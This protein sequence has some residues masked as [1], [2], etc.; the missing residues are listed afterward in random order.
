MPFSMVNQLVQVFAAIFV[1]T[2]GLVL[3]DRLPSL[4]ERRSFRV[5]LAFGALGAVLLTAYLVLQ[6]QWLLFG[7]V[8]GYLAQA[9]LIQSFRTPPGK[10]YRDFFGPEGLVELRTSL[11]PRDDMTRM[12]LR[13][14]RTAKRQGTECASRITTALHVSRNGDGL[15]LLSVTDTYQ[16]QM[17]QELRQVLVL[18]FPV[19]SSSPKNGGPVT[20]LAQH[21]AKDFGDKW[22]IYYAPNVS[23]KTWSGMA[24]GVKATVFVSRSDSPASKREAMV[25]RYAADGLLRFEAPLELDAQW[26]TLTVSVS[27]FP[28]I[29][30]TFHFYSWMAATDYWEFAATAPPEDTDGLRWQLSAVTA[31]VMPV[32]V[33]SVGAAGLI[34]L[35]ARDM[36]VLPD[37]AV[38]A[39]LLPD[40]E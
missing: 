25:T 31:G 3:A 20:T 39:R 7:V 40:S 29:G 1:F 19:P 16:L 8:V 9:M 35:E 33:S 37:D 38:I 36:I 17:T 12:M 34:R 4:E 18:Y 24:G 27:G 5:V 14:C 22:S 2:L 15:W 6:T 21:R 26:D 32:K 30:E 13:L 11:L 10:N 23:P 28:H